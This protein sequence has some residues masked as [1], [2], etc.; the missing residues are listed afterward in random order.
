MNDDELKQA[1]EELLRNYP[2]TTLRVR[3]VIAELIKRELERS[4]YSE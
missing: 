3:Q 1:K 4:R 2:V